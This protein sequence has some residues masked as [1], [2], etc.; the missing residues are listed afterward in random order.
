MT[1][2]YSKLFSFFKPGL[3]LVGFLF[4][5][6]IAQAQIIDAP[7]IN[8][9]PYPCPGS[10]IE[11]SF[12]VTNGPG[13]FISFSPFTTN[14]NYTPVLY[15]SASDS[16]IIASFTSNIRPAIWD[17]S[18]AI[19]TD[20]IILPASVEPG[21]GY[22][23]KI[24]SD[25]NNATSPLSSH[26]SIGTTITGITPGSRCGPGAV[27]LGAT[28]STG[29]INWYSVPTGGVSLGTGTTF[30]TPVISSTTTYYVDATSNACT[31]GTRTAVLA[32]VNPIP[33]V[34][35]TT[36]GSRCGPGTVSL[37]A[38]ASTGTI[39]WYSAPT[40]GVSLGTGTTFTT[41]VISSTTT[42]YVDATSNACTTGT[43]TAVLAI[44]NSIPAV[45][46]TTPGSRCGPG[47]VS[48]QATAS[49][50][51]IKWYSAPIGGVSLGTGTTFTTPVI[52]S[53][54]TYYVDA[55]SNTCTTGSRTA[56]L[57]TVNPIPTVTS[58]TPGSRCGPG[59]V[60]LGATASAGTIK[61]YS[62]AT[63]GV[64]LG[65][66]TTFTTPVIS[67]TTTYYVDAT[68]NTCTTGS[69]TAVLATVNSIPPTPIASNNGPICEE[70]N[71]QLTT[72]NISGATYQWTGPNGFTA[73]GR[74]PSRSNVNAAM[75]G[76]YTVTASV[77]G[78]T[79]EAATTT[80]GVNV[81]NLSTGDENAA[82]TESWIGHVYNGI[83]FQAYLGT[84][85]EE[86]EFVQDFGG[87]FNCFEVSSGN[88]NNSVYSE[89]FSVRYR[90]TS[91]L[92]GLYSMNLGSDDGSRLSINNVLVYDDWNDHAYRNK[93]IL[94]SLS[95]E[96]ELVLDY[97]ENG[98]GNSISVGKPEL[99]IENYLDENISQTLNDQNSPQTISGDE[100]GTLPSGMS[101][102]G[103]GYKWVY[104]TVEDGA[105]SDI[106]GA[107][108]AT[109]T[110]DPKFFDS[111][112]TYYV[113]RIATLT[114]SNNNM[115][116]AYRASI[117]SNPAVITVID[118]SEA[119]T[120]S[121]TAPSTV[122]AGQTIITGSLT[123]TAPWT[124]KGKVNGQ[125]FNIVFNT[126]VFN[127]PIDIQQSTSIEILNIID[128]K[129]CE[130][131][132][133]DEILNIN[134]INSI[135]NNVIAGSME[136]CTVLQSVNLSGEDLG[137]GYSYL[138]EVSTIS[139][140]SGFTAAPGINDKVDYKTGTV[141]TTT[142]YRRIVEVQHCSSNISNVVEV[143]IN[144]DFYTWT[145]AVD[146]DWNNTANWS[147]NTLP[148]LDIDVLIPGGLTNY[149]IINTGNNALAKDLTIEPDASVIVGNIWLQIAG[150]IYNSG[151]LNAENGSV[152][153]EG[154]ISQTIPIGAFEN[155]RIL[156]LN[157]KNT[158]G[159]TSQAYIKILNSL[160]VEK[161]IFNTGNSLL[162]VSTEARTA[163]ID[164][165]GAGQVV[166]TVRMQ[167]YLPNAFGYKYFSSPF[168]NSTV[169]NLASIF[170]LA[171]TATGF[172]HFYEY[173]EDRK[174]GL[175]N[176]LTG[177]Q[178]YLD[179]AAPLQPGLG[180]AINPSGA[181]NPLMLELSGN[182]NNG[183]IEVS[184]ENNKGTYT[185]GFNLV[186]NPYPSPID[187]DMMVP[188]LTGIDN[189]VYFF[190]ATAGDRYTGT[191]T[192]YIDGLS[193][194]GR[195]SSIIPS[196]QGFFVRVSDPGSGN[197][198][199][200]AQLEF[201]NTV[202]TGNQQTQQYYQAQKKNGVS[203]IRIT[204]GFKG[205]EASDATLLYFKNGA[206]PNFEKT[207]DAQKLLNT[208]VEVPSFYSL[209]SKRE[210][211]AINAIP[212]FNSE[213][214]QIPLGITAAKSGEMLLRLSEVSNTSPFLHIY[215]RD[216][217]KK[218][219]TEFIESATY[220]FTAQKGE[221]DDRFALLFS[222]EKLT[223]AQMVLATQD[224][225]VYTKD[226]EIIV[227]L[228]LLNNAKGKISIS[229]VSGQLLQ[230]KTGFGT[231]E[232]RFSRNFVEGVYL[233]T[234]ETEKEKYT[235]KI[236]FKN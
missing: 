206:T 4:F 213:R 163:Y 57:A 59:T 58:T 103:N 108:S 227:K 15:R 157:V 219:L 106:P 74:T 162:L 142:W 176:D 216:S 212:Q 154:T 67:S 137:E 71:L 223:E 183:P 73:T 141:S 62:A 182:V 55:T 226:K 229:N 160:K 29:T 152:S 179:V 124:I 127:V 232:V 112:G 31:T 61:W 148:T 199:A 48:L 87:N 101:A 25:N 19:I 215:L 185:N 189:A 153:F 201:A 39:N 18:T 92:K 145:G 187:W 65:T 76:V 90:M 113:Y 81:A 85:F 133:P 8:N 130:N 202:R 178:K 231:E 44:V 20:S 115:S 97:Y 172:P 11:I 111:E 214:L 40:G 171:D 151:V 78:C 63:G 196:M 155:D 121:L 186:G 134:V 83:N 68:S 75:A 217:K 143:R 184:L 167:R 122:C 12:K 104:S 70:G 52:S 169:G 27:R 204:A 43:R 221:N 79:S 102:Y 192:S 10:S 14:T 144:S 95:G 46:S 3:L 126:S 224:F 35:S 146:T 30:T 91:S 220:T 211:L 161:G 234:L 77:N 64:S 88:G 173:I 228:N 54:T 123:G 138:W 99:L 236:L 37:Q 128:G 38:I 49:T 50:G 56:V 132:F 66:G 13:F 181:V 118:C 53:T 147:C 177:W 235:R 129:G 225:S 233:V 222:S 159:V 203:K 165:R 136:S 72:T 60:S 82:G 194:D 33:T 195:S 16:T 210:K 86:E 17:G 96:S 2:N 218:L 139:A 9:T 47:T 150:D 174:D 1:K 28:A 149:P 200:T 191:Y 119:P 23:L 131:S 114:T 116:S 41:P 207:L 156:N 109:Y 198:P 24:I 193:T 170:P 6:F 26:F 7:I 168:Q 5:G 80:V 140:T 110:P 175:G 84:Y 94:I 51:T 107:N 190:A 42:Y 21:S 230:S 32:T 166:G 100:I 164:G 197:Y 117:I 105:S 188:S 22:T 98:G 135:D 209:S 36:P 205:E 158:A 69:R 125:D 120:L 45:T 93:N 34:T 208:A 180:Y 89:T